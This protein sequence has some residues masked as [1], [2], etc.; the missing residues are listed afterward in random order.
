MTLQNKI[1]GDLNLEFTTVPEKGEELPLDEL[2]SSLGSGYS[3]QLG[4]HTNGL[5]SRLVGGKMPGGL[6]LMS[7]KGYMNKI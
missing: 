3:G 1:L 7:I 6:K 5:I 2:G 4:K